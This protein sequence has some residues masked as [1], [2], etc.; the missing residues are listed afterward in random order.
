MKQFMRLLLKIFGLLFVLVVTAGMLI[1]I[2]LVGRAEQLVRDLL[3]S[4]CADATG[5]PCSVESIDLELFAGTLSINKLRIGNPPGYAN[6]DLLTIDSIDLDVNLF[7]LIRSPIE[8]GTIDVDGIT[9]DYQ[10]LHGASNLRTVLDHAKAATAQMESGSYADLPIQVQR[11]ALDRTTVNIYIPG[12][13]PISNP[14]SL[15][16]RL[17]AIVLR[18]PVNARGELP[19]A[20]ELLT[21]ISEKITEGIVNHPQVPRV[22]THV[23]GSTVRN[24]LNLRNVPI[25]IKGRKDQ[26]PP[27]PQQQEPD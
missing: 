11:I 3:V 20:E 24:M 23:L 15:R 4:S 21:L 7:S 13:W 8:V 5:T 18:R 16:L 10:Q 17:P 25:R 9:V 19:N 6:A 12:I 2:H 27:P 1:G 22:V 26:P 14:I